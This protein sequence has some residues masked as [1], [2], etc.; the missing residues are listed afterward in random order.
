M[1][2]R[3]LATLALATACTAPL[4]VNARTTKSEWKETLYCAVSKNLTV[5]DASPAGCWTVE[6]KG[7]I[8]TFGENHEFSSD[9]QFIIIS[10]YL[11]GHNTVWRKNDTKPALNAATG[12][13][14]DQNA[15]LSRSKKRTVP[16]SL[17]VKRAKSYDLK[18]NSYGNGCFAFV[19]KGGSKGERS[20]Y[21]LGAIAFNRDG[22][23]MTLKQQQ[24]V[25]QSIRIKH[26]MYKAPLNTF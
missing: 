22:S 4:L 17:W 2:N 7:T 1:K 13:L 24:T 15:V 5:L 21:M 12:F 18:T 19:S 16:F 26:P 9:R 3:W 20:S 14:E 8:N 10:L 25:S 11:A 6:K 23:P